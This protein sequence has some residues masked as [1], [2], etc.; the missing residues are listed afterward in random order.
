[1]SIK[2]MLSESLAYVMS[3]L[4]YLIGPCSVVLL[5]DL[6]VKGHAVRSKLAYGVS[7]RFT[8]LEYVA[9]NVVE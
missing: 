6:N 9:I 8:S 1:M 3:S 4:I 2:V 5:S 7:Y